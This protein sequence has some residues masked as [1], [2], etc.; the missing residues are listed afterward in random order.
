MEFAKAIKLR[1]FDKFNYVIDNFQLALCFLLNGRRV[2]ENCNNCAL[3]ES[4]LNFENNPEKFN[5]FT[6][7]LLYSWWDLL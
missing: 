3:K 6:D 1:N 7:K 4:C 2:D 5:E